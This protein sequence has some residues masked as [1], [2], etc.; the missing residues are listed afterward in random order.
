MAHYL[1]LQDVASARGVVERAL[2]FKTGLSN[3]TEDQERY[4][5]WMAYLNMEAS[6]GTKK[7]LDEVFNHYLDERSIQFLLSLSF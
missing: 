4:N 5:V 2:G 7:S 6:F 1:K 3:F